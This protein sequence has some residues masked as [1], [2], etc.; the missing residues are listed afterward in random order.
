MITV[1]TKGQAVKRTGKTANGWSR[2][3]V[4][5]VTGY[6]YSD[7]LSTSKN[8]SGS[9]D[10]NDSSS[11]ATI[12]GYILP[13]SNSKNYTAD[14]LSGLSKSELRLARNEIYA[15]HGRKFTDAS[16]QKYFESCTWYKGTIDA[17]AFDANVS[18]YL[19]SYELANLDLIKSL[20]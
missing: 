3:E 6:V 2:I 12:S 16:L 11:G 8:S 5:G 14:E 1:L 18:S 4:G 9:D 17:A 10:D 7:Y 13:K 15:R 19:N 20:E